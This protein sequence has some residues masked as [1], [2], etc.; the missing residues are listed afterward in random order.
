MATSSRVAGA[1]KAEAVAKPWHSCRAMS[2]SWQLRSPACGQRCSRQ[3]EI[4]IL[5]S[6]P[7]LVHAGVQGNEFPKGRTG[8]GPCHG[9]C[10]VRYTNTAGSGEQTVPAIPKSVPGKGTGVHNS[11]PRRGPGETPGVQLLPGMSF[12]GEE[13]WGGSTKPQSSPRPSP[14]P[15]SHSLPKAHSGLWTH[16]PTL[17]VQTPWLLQL[18][19]RKPALEA[20]GS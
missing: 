11:I 16:S 2:S 3:R 12:V 1:G 9:C 17:S 15:T 10:A 8:T 6:H 14:F 18:A 20:I 5:H 4:K 7:A 13:N 19:G